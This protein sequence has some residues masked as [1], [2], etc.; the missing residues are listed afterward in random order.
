MSEYTE[1]LAKAKPTVTI[2]PTPLILEKP[3][4]MFRGMYLGLKTFDKTDPKTGEVKTLPIAHFYDGT[5]V[6][7][8]M[9]AQLTRAV[10]LLK[11]GVSVEI[12]LKEL[13]PNT[14]GGK[15]KIYAISPLDIPV[16]NLGEMFGGMLA[17]NAPYPKHMLTAPD[18]TDP[19]FVASQ[20]FA[21]KHAANRAAL[22]G[23]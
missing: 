18:Y 19:N 15:T 16:E 9:G 2:T 10:E 6:L 23:E 4:A 13:K 5:G 17:I 7:F 22:F 20:I 11:P 8:N 3:G 14:H 1:K 21:D 12:V